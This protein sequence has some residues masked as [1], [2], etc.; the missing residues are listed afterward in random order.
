MAAAA[1]NLGRVIGLSGRNCLNLSPAHLRARAKYRR[2]REKI[3]TQAGILV[4]SE[5][6]T[7]FQQSP[8]RV[9]PSD[10]PTDLCSRVPTGNFRARSIHAHHIPGPVV[11]A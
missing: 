11:V 5:C 10:P 2:K 8:A 4:L 1:N 3:V 7:N 9:L 6:L